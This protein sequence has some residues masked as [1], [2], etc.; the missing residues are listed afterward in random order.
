V[1]HNKKITY[2]FFS[3]LRSASRLSETAL[4]G[5]TAPTAPLGLVVF[6]VRL[7]G[8]FVLAAQTS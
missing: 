6:C 7:Q 1:A 5:S 2:V 3:F 4:I 8:V